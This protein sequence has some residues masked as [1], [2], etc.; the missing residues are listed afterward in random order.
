MPVIAVKP[1]LLRDVVMDVKLVGAGTADSYQNHVSRVQI[2]PSSTTVR[3]RGLAPAAKYAAQTAPDWSVELAYAQDW[4][5]ANSLSAY[6]L[7]NDG[8]EAEIT[9]RP[10]GG[11]TPG[12]KVTVLLTA[13]PI[14]GDVDTVASGTVTMGVNGVPVAAP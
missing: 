12:W 11:V 4:E 14:G 9:F 13:G 8:K 3:W 7:A 5:T 1:I 6:L 10:R 2:T